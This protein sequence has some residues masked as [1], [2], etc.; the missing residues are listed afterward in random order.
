[1]SDNGPQANTEASIKEV[2]IT[3]LKLGLT[4]FGGPVAHLG[5]F[6]TTFVEQKRWLSSS[7]YAELVALCQFIPGPASSQVGFAIGLHRAGLGGAIAAWIG[8][9]LP[10]ALLMLLLG[11]SLFHLD[12]SS[13]QGLLQGLKVTAVAVVTWAL[14]SMAKSLTPDLP[15]RGIAL[16]GALVALSIPGVLG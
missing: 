1:M 10:S 6:Q 8:F 7:A 11:V 2:F 15:R 4:A 9:T 12:L 14:W 3:F 13:Y 16:L 5:F